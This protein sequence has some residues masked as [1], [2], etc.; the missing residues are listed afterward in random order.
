MENEIK[1]IWVTASENGNG[2]YYSEDGK[3]GL[4]AI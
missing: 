2:L 3:T 1:K 4:K